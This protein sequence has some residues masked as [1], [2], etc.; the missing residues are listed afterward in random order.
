[1]SLRRLISSPRTASWQ[2]SS[3]IQR[4]LLFLR[5]NGQEGRRFWF[6][7]ER[8]AK[9]Y[10]EPNIPRFSKADEQKLVEDYKECHISGD[11][12][13][14]ELYKRKISS[15]LVVLEEAQHDNWTVDRFVC[16]GDS[17][18]KMTPNM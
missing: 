2:I 10:F 1:M 11:I 13:F 18:H 8:T 15:V 5:D 16:L 4:R 6:V 17:I 9:R 12:T 14:D 3:R 7:F